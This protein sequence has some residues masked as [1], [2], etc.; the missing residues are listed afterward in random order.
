MV[1]NWNPDWEATSR[2]SVKWLGML[3]CAAGIGV[4]SAILLA[5][6][7]RPAPPAMA[8]SSAAG[9]DISP[10]AG[11]FGGG[12]AS[13]VKIVPSGL[14]A[15]GRSGTAILAVDGGRAQAFAVGQPL[16]HDMVL[17]AVLPHGVV[18]SQGGQ[19]V[20]LAIPELPRSDG[21]RP[22]AVNPAPVSLSAE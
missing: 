15:A 13:R 17:E 20:E 2:R 7:P 4:W 5:P 8:T 6:A 21:I 22:V 16:A 12:P 11:W 14:I 9:T 18:V 10:V 19:E 1:R 3:A